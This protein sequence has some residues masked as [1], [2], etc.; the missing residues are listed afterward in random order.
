[1]AFPIRSIMLAVVDTER[2]VT[3]VCGLVRYCDLG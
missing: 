1:M 2:R 3:G